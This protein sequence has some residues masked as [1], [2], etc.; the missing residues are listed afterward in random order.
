MAEPG[1]VEPPAELAEA[2]AEADA[3]DDAWN[4][5]APFEGGNGGT[6]LAALPPG[7]TFELTDKAGFAISKANKS[8][9]IISELDENL[10]IIF[11]NLL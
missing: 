11:I 2:D 4:I 1:S 9:Q 7:R 6:E 5:W 3:A 10:C 8:E